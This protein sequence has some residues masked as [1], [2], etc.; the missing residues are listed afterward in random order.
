MEII[1][2]LQRSRPE[3]VHVFDE[4][5]RVLPEGVYLTYLKQSGNRFELR[6]VAQSSTRVSS[7]MRNIDASQWL[8]DPTLQI[9]ETRAKDTA[10]GA[11]FTLFA[12][13]AAPGLGRGRR[14]RDAYRQGQE[15]GGRQMNQLQALFEQLRNLDPNDPGRWPLGVRIGTAVLLFLVAAAGGYYFL[16]WKS[17]RPLLLEARRDGRPAAGIADHQGQA[18]R[19][20][21]CLPRPARRNG[22]IL[23]RD[24]AAAAEQ[25][26]GAEPA[27]RHLADR[28]RGGPRGEAVPAAG[29]EPEGLLRRAADQHPPDGRLSRDGQVRE[30]HRC[31]A[32]HRDSAR[33]RD[34]AGQ[35]QGRHGPGR[36]RRSTSPR[37][38]IATS[39]KRSRPRRSRR[40]PRARPRRTARARRS[41]LRAR[42]D[43]EHDGEDTVVRLPARAARV[44]DR[45]AARGLRQRH[46]RAAGQGRRD[47]E[48]IRVPASSRCP[49]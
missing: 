26:R 11:S 7:F 6:G 20:P 38:P 41:P 35:R 42:H 22:E 17:K 15:E 9:V 39:T 3:I 30:R 34:H 44:V 49:R 32:A 45:A 2:T 8:A 29:R 19:E 48:R 27:G 33:H 14:G 10:G 25:D 12:E 23:R 5:V 40:K 28:P 4:L 21:G 16:V 18:R 24:A 36:T 1:E 46:G 47:Q 13:P 43:H 37:R 31:A